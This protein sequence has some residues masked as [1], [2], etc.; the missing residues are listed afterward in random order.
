[1]QTV[2]NVLWFFIVAIPVLSTG[3]LFF[4]HYDKPESD[5]HTETIQLEVEEPVLPPQPPA[6]PDVVRIANQKC[7]QIQSLV[8]QDVDLKVWQKGVKLKLTAALFFEKPKRFRM[9]VRSAFG[10]EGDF[11]T[12]DE[13]FWFWSK[14]MEPPGLFYAH[15]Q[16]LSKTDMKTE[17]NPSFMVDSMCL[18][19]IDVTKTKIVEREQDFLVIERFTDQQGQKLAKINYFRKSDQRLKGF[20]ISTT[21]GKAIMSAEV[22]SFE[23]EVPKQIY[24]VWPRDQISVL[25]DLNAPQINPKVGGSTW[26]MPDIQPKTNMA[27]W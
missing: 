3:Y 21:E 5:F 16:D 25:M 19:A 12:N 22:Q 20:V 7:D 23:G 9:M 1:M 26:T 13:L 8:C 27:K 10:K 18:S 15:H 17:Y 2:K 14:R 11:G 6:I 24:F 4:Y